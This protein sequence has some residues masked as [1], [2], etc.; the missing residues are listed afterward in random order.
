MQLRHEHLVMA[1]QGML[2]IEM[3]RQKTKRRFSVLLLPVALEILRSRGYPGKS[4]SLL[5]MISN[6]KLNAYLKELAI[7]AGID[8]H[9]THHVARKRSLQPYY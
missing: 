6:Q 3:I 8:K 9:L 5:P 2:W 1:D 7:E 4:G